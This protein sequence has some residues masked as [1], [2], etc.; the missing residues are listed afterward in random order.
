METAAGGRDG[1]AH[2]ARAREATPAVR[3]SRRLGWNDDWQAKAPA[4]LGKECI[5]ILVRSFRQHA[6]GCVADV[7]RLDAWR[8]AAGSIPVRLQSQFQPGGAFGR[9][10]LAPVSFG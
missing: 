10:A 8:P 3:T 2:P 7:A 5:L 6:E 1:R 9:A 4:P